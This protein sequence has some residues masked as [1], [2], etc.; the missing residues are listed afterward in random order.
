[1]PTVIGVRFRT[2]GRLYYYDPDGIEFQA[3]DLAL[4]DAGNRRELGRVILAPTE[5]DSSE[6]RGS[7]KKVVRRATA[8]DRAQAEQLS[9]HAERAMA[10][11]SDLIKERD[12]PI[13]PIKAGW[14]MDNST[15]TFNIATSGPVAYSDLAAELAG[16]FHARIELRQVGSRERAALV[17]GL[18]RC[19][20]SLCCSSWL[21]EP[22]NVTVRMAKNQNLPLNPAKISGVCGR[23]LCCLRYEHEMYVAGTVPQR[24]PPDRVGIPD[25]FLG[26]TPLS[27]IPVP[28][29]TE[30]EPSDQPAPTRR[31]RRPG[32]RRR[33]RRSRRRGQ[34]PR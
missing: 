1:M 30:P 24:E 27:E 29:E 28:E 21:T 31:R 15:L 7:L 32:R 11:F 9:E 18:G 2:A 19:G 20:L 22:G 3:D 10:E 33:S 16:R 23:L 5:I 14:S 25:L 13:K 34:R 17:D 6:L 8:E 26:G 12:L 4:V